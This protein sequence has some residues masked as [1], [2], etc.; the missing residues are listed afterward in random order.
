M[1]T[2]TEAKDVISFFCPECGNRIRVS[3]KHVGQKGKCPTCEVTVTVPDRSDVI[4]IDDAIREESPSSIPESETKD[5]ATSQT[6]SQGRI[7]M[8]ASKRFI[9][10]IVALVGTTA[11]AV[12]RPSSTG[13]TGNQKQVWFMNTE[14][15]ELVAIDQ[16]EGEISPIETET[17]A[18][19]V[20]AHVFSCDTC[21]S[22]SITIGYMEKHTPEGLAALRARD[23][24]TL[25]T[26]SDSD[27][28]I[29]IGDPKTRQ[30]HSES[31]PEAQKLQDSYAVKKC[32]N[33][34]WLRAC[35]PGDK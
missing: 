5:V 23:W 3:T 19:L 16:K 31:G 15:G 8:F 11:F 14:S 10:F 26:L 35:S 4:E 22:K 28:A 29:V 17:G 20:R 25:N 2:D 30:W 18:E 9:L 32:K 6:P 34:K 12:F 21:D 13:S 27:K 7:P 33:G 24:P 1:S